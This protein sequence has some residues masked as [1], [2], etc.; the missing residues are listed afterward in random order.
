MQNCYTYIIKIYKKHAK[1]FDKKIFLID[2]YNVKTEEKRKS[3]KGGKYVYF[4]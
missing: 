2:N 1:I 3:Y 4:Q